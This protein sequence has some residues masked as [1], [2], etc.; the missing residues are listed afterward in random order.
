MT[1]KPT[2]PA[3]TLRK[4]PFHFWSLPSLFICPLQ[5]R[6]DKSKE[7]GLYPTAMSIQSHTANLWRW[8]R[9]PP[10][11]LITQSHPLSTR[12][13]AAICPTSDPVLL[14]RLRGLQT[15][16]SNTPLPCPG[17]QCDTQTNTSHIGTVT[18]CHTA[19]TGA[20]VPSASSLHAR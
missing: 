2:V 14:L 18:Q 7:C 6:A 1:H 4:L 16:M 3:L 5:C 10:I 17:T 9:P 13:L 12:K 8:R 15:T 19:Q 11:E 20:R